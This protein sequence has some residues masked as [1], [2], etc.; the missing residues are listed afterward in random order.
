MMS[1]RPFLSRFE[2]TKISFHWRQIVCMCVCFC[3]SFC[4]CVCPLAVSRVLHE[5]SSHPLHTQ[6]PLKH[7]HTRLRRALS[8]SAATL[9]LPDQ[10]YRF[11]NK[12]SNVSMACARLWWGCLNH[13]PLFRR[14][15]TV[16]ASEAL[17]TTERGPQ[18]TSAVGHVRTSWITG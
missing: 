7:S 12:R 5:I 11:A 17:L 15:A 9:P 8:Q 10:G 2:C 16:A 4:I 6:T 1:S 14:K 18:Q 13:L 3:G